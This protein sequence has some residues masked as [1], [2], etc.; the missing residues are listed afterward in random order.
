MKMLVLTGVTL[1]VLLVVL[2]VELWTLYR[3]HM[4]IEQVS[5]MAERIRGIQRVLSMVDSDE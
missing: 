2:W 4:L 1:M 5:V 3:L